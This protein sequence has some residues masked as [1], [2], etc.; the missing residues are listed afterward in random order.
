MLLVLGENLT[1]FSHV[2]LDFSK[3]T[4]IRVFKFFNLHS[5]PR[6]TRSNRKEKLIGQSSMFSCLEIVA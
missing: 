3:P 6:L 5:S 2:G 1:E 4:L